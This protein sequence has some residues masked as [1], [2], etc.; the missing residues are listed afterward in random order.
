MKSNGEWG[1]FFPPSMA[2]FPYN[3]SLG[4]VYFPL[5]K[6][7]ALKRGFQL[8]YPL[9]DNI[10]GA[11]NS[12]SD[13]VIT[14]E[15]SG[16]KF[17]LI[18]Q[19]LEFYKKMHLPLPKLHPDVRMNKR[20]SMLSAYKL[21]KRT[22]GKCEKEIQTTYSPKRPEKVYCESCYLNEVY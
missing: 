6:E 10:S 3:D 22:C 4:S 5:S 8:E 18:P 2:P 16:R 12:T 19:E 17:K 20:S 1:E 9:A 15:Q 21:F 11:T 14:C 13:E 7:E